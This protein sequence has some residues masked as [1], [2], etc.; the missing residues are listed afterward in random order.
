LGGPDDG[1]IGASGWRESEGGEQSRD[2]VHVGSILWRV[3][4]GTSR[5]ALRMGIA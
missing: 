3:G 5:A 2:Y 1:E 4:A